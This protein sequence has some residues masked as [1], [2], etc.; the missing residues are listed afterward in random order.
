MSDDEFDLDF[1]S[2]ATRNVQNNWKKSF[3][4]KVD[5]RTAKTTSKTKL[6]CDP[7]PTHKNKKG[8]ENAAEN[9]TEE[10]IELLDSDEDV[11]LT[12]PGSPQG[13]TP[14]TVRGAK[15]TKKT[16]KALE[17]LK[18]KTTVME[19]SSSRRSKQGKGNTS[20]GEEGLLLIS[21]EEDNSEKTFDLKV[22]WKSDIVRV[23][24]KQ[25]EK[26][27]KVM[28]RVAEK[29]GVTVGEISLY[30][31]ENSEEQILRDSTVSDLGLSIVSVVYGRGR[32]ITEDA[33]DEGT[34]Q[35][36]LQTKDR[37]AQP[38]LLDIM[39]TDTMETVMDKFSSQAGLDRDKLKFFFDGEVLDG[40][41]TAEDLELEGGE[42][43]DVHMAS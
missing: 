19:K 4:K 41:S 6:D 25:N 16:Q 22:R 26:M 28:D 33:K 10:N 43:I 2:A 36:K 32:V 17:Q 18:T 31:G 7:A 38:V 1:V 8:K 5:S 11:T 34:I 29:V 27:G 24:V 23:A 35:V 15:M 12:P 21:D 9:V 20:L 14:K 13:A 37:R 42:C 39:P 3:D 40:S 30:Q